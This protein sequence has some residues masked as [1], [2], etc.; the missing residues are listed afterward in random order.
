MIVIKLYNQNLVTGI[1]L[2]CD[3]HCDV[4]NPLTEG[5]KELIAIK[6]TCAFV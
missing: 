1:R 4:G 3:L 2:L 5:R 6:Q